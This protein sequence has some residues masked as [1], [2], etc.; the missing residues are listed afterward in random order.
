VLEQRNIAR[1]GH[2]R[3]VTPREDPLKKLAG[4]TPPTSSEGAGPR[5][6]SE[7]SAEEAAIKL[8]P[9]TSAAA[10]PVQSGQT[11]RRTS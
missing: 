5:L 4:F 2:K 6:N 7:V 10:R 1:F 11:A 8:P 3:L 9:L